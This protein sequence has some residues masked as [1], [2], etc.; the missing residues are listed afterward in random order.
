M[1]QK[2]STLDTSP[3]KANIFE[4]QLGAKAELYRYWQIQKY[5]ISS[6]SVV[7]TVIERR[8]STLAISAR[9]PRPYHQKYS[10]VLTNAAAAFPE[11]STLILVVLPHEDLQL[12]P[13]MK[14]W[15]DFEVSTPTICMTLE[16]F[17][18]IR[19]VDKDLTA[20]ANVR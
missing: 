14:R 6:R 13:E 11:K 9:K 10:K 4:I 12:H 3:R 18:K 8:H 5:G 16:K 2:S 7:T 1:P 15:A 19:D 20:C 17:K